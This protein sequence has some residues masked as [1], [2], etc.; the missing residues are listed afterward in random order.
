M[1][2]LCIAAFLLSLTQRNQPLKGKKDQKIT[3]AV[4]R[5]K[6]DK[7]ASRLCLV[8]PAQ[9]VKM[10]PRCPPRIQSMLWYRG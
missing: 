1:P 8:V 2:S 9:C 4:L 10:L 3:S 6:K 5:K 7:V